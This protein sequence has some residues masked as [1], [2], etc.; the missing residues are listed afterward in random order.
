MSVL[1]WPITVE[2]APFRPFP[3]ARAIAVT[4]H[5]ADHWIIDNS[6]ALI[7]IGRHWISPW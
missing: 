4:P 1:A 6:D 7:A 3:V 2:I 5:T